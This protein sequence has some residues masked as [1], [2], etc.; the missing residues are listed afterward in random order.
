MPYSCRRQDAGATAGFRRG[1]RAVQADQERDPHAHQPD[2]TIHSRGLHHSRGIGGAVRRGR[3]RKAA[4]GG[5]NASRS[6]MDVTPGKPLGTLAPVLGCIADANLQARHAAHVHAPALEPGL[7][8][9]RSFAFLEHL[10][11]RVPDK[12]GLCTERHRG[13][14]KPCQSN[15]HPALALT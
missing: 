15:H 5:P 10:A 12:P 14:F 8:A 4:G 11:D 1:L 6:L 9:N 13:A 3:H 2:A 7:F